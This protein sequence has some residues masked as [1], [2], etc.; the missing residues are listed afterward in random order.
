LRHDD[1]AVVERALTCLFVV[2]LSSEV[3]AVEQLLDHPDESVSKA[4][5]ICAFE[6]RRRPAESE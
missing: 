4:A 6:L 5:R 1:P 3:N 2:G